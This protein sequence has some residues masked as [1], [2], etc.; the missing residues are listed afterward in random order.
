MEGFVARSSSASVPLYRIDG[1]KHLDTWLKTSPSGN[2][3]RDFVPRWVTASEF[4]AKAGQVLLVPDKHGALSCILVGV[5]GIEPLWQVAKL[6][7]LLPKGKYHLADDVAPTEADALCLGWGLG[8]Y[9]FDRYKKTRRSAAQLVWPTTADRHRV[10]TLVEA[11]SMGRDWINTPA[12]DM[13]PEQLSHAAQRVARECDAT[14]N[15]VVGEALIRENYPAIHAVGRA[16]HRAPRLIEFTWGKLDAP[17]VTLV[18][19]GVCFDTGGLDLK[20]ADAMKLMKKDM[21]GAA[22]VLA[23]AYAVMKLELPVRL[24]VLIPA[25]ENS[26][27]GN[28]FRPL[29]VLSTRKGLSVEVGNTDA[30]GRLV[31]SDALT[32]ADGDSPELLIDMATLTGA[33]RVA[34]GTDLPALFCNSDELATQLL[35][36]SNA[37]SDPLWRLPLHK[38]YRRL[39]DSKV[40]DLNNVSS[41]SY[42]GAITAALFLQEFVSAKTP[43]I[44][45]DSMAFNLETQPG[46]PFGGETFG[47]RALLR[48]LETRYAR[49][50]KARSRRA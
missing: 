41:G 39:L 33:A 28:A 14:F 10:Q 5:A 11:I 34:L 6:P 27:A 38:P 50:G 3:R 4:V 17:K 7:A 24:R 22:C 35:E 49:K 44:H 1:R 12:E 13:G 25:V 40:A 15:E 46:R 31:L 43:W 21:G 30:E 29:D 8:L 20:P 36:V 9:T 37:E 23:L 19:K 18:G 2:E 42:A 48:L 47:V 26:V 16:S 45:I 32:E